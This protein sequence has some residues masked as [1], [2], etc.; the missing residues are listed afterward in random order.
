[1]VPPGA[2]IRLPS[3]PDPR[4]QCTTTIDGHRCPEPV[5]EAGVC[6]AH[7]AHAGRRWR[8]QAIDPT[9]TVIHDSRVRTDRD[10][11]DAIHAL[12]ARPDW[13]LQHRVRVTPA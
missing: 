1:M 3:D 8:L 6:P 13:T 7:R 9:N 4:W 5:T 12:E 11:N 2:D 10:L